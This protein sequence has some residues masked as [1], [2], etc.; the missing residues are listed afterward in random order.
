MMKFL[1]MVSVGLISMTVNAKT[2]VVLGDSISAGY[3][4]DVNAGWVP[5]LEKKLN[6]NGAHH[7]V[8]NESISGDTTAGG[9]ARLNHAL[10][11]KPNIFILELGA[12]DGLRGFQ[13]SL[14]K[15]NL[16]QIIQRAQQTGTKVVLLSMKIPPNYGDRYITLFYDIYP[17]LA[18]ELNT[19]YVPFIMEDVALTKE[20]MQADGLHPNEKG[21][22][23]IM[24][25]V[26]AEVLPLLK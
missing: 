6:E 7:V 26:L 9:L 19:A 21:Q 16:T 23:A 5:L 10:D 18:K 24:N 8:H 12:N 11:F 17:Q 25:K 13:P 4:I 1:F 3:G 20:M 2:V 14:I 22:P 15:K